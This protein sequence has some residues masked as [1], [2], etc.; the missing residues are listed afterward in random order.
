MAVLT[1]RKVGRPRKVT[2]EESYELFRR[3]KER[4]NLSCSCGTVVERL[5]ADTASVICSSCVQTMVPAPSKPKHIA[6][7]NK[8]KRPR[9]WHFKKKYVSPSGK[10]YSFGKEVKMDENTNK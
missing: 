8:E 7:A 10:V 3:K 9:G 2:A 6:D 1:R 5:D 4:V